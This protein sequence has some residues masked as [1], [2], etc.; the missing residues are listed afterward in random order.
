MK[1]SGMEAVSVNVN[2]GTGNAGTGNIGTGNSGAGNAGVVIVSAGQTRVGYNAEA[3][4]EYGGV[5]SSAQKAAALQQRIFAGAASA[6][7][8]IDGKKQ[9]YTQEDPLYDK[10][11]REAIEKANR[12]LFPDG[13]KF[14]ITIHEKTKEVLI[15]VIDTNTNETIKEIPPKKIVDLVVSLCEMA[16]I[17]LDAKG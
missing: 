5:E 13:R 4:Q 15:K 16:G 9:Q 11:L 6:F 12:V 10:V 14:E 2:A 3:N 7:T 17:I 8:V 1:L